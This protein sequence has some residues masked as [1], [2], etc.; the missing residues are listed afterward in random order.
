M[1]VLVG[2]LTGPAMESNSR[3]ILLCKMLVHV[4]ELWL[5]K[6]APRT[7]RSQSRSFVFKGTVMLVQRVSHINDNLQMYSTNNKSSC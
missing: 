5:W 7:K 4:V 2:V 1:G 6:I 3:L